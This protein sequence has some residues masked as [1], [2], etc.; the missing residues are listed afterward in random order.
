M[1][2]DRGRRGREPGRICARAAHIGDRSP[3][4][5]ALLRLPPA[6][7]HGVRPVV[8]VVFEDEDEDEDED[9]LVAS[10]FLQL[11][12]PAE[13]NRNGLDVPCV[14]RDDDCSRRRGHL[15]RVVEPA[16]EHRCAS[17]VRLAFDYGEQTRDAVAQ[18]MGVLVPHRVD[19]V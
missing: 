8:F 13:A 18:R 5:S 6:Y 11:L 1:D 10:H 9:E 17:R 4:S 15:R 2:R 3:I 14:S 7:N 12:G 19:I 16:E